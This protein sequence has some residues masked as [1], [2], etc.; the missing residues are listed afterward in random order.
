MN[1]ILILS[2]GRRVELAEIFRQETKKRELKAKVYAVDVYPEHSAACQIVDQAYAAPRVTDP[3]YLEFLLRLCQKHEI[4]LVVPTIDTE[5]ALLAEHRH[6]F[7]AIGVS[8][9]ISTLDFVLNCR[10][11][12]RT[13]DLFT[14]LKIDS[15]SI[16]DRDKLSFPCFAKPYDG[17]CSVGARRIEAP[18]QMTADL[19]ADKKMIFMELIGSNYSEYTVDVYFDRQESLRCLVPRKRVEVRAGEVS[20]GITHKNHVYNYLLNRLH[21]VKGARGCINL[22]LFVAD[23]PEHILGIEINPRFG[24]GFP[25][26]DSAGANFVGWLLD[27]YLLGKNIPFYDQWEDNLLMLRYDAKILVHGAD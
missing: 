22:Q 4:G 23:D 10:D 3:F 9:V 21:K 13:I 11:K 15:P 24:G 1:N 5:L 2:A 12:R 25:L 19:L 17:S 27:E 14:D 8:L 20:K 6:K 16:Y 7:D 26:S 18:N